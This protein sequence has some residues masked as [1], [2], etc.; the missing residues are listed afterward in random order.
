MYWQLH[1]LIIHLVSDD[2]AINLLWQRLLRGWNFSSS[3]EKPPAIRLKLAIVDEL[4]LLSDLTPFFSDTT[5]L[6]EDKRILSV[7]DGEGDSVRLYFHDGALIDVPLA[8]PSFPEVPTARG[9]LTRN[10]LNHG[11]FED[12]TF[13][14]LAPLLRRKG[15]FMVHAFGAAKD[16]QAALIVGPSGSGKTTTGLNLLL[17]DWDLLA[18]DVVLLKKQQNRILALPT[19]GGIGIRPQTVQLLPALRNLI[20]ARSIQ[21]QMDVTDAI[22]NITRW[23]EPAP[24][25]AVYFPQIEERSQ[26]S[27]QPKIKAVCLAE[28]MA[29]SMDQWDEALLPTHMNIL[30]ELS[31]QAEAY[32]LHLGQ[33]T[34]QIPSLLTPN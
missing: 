32:T 12:I 15:L 10:A 16:G 17:A 3:N 29:E 14:S 13:T 28:L 2:V 26:S 21:Q 18:N 8:T 30:Q 6:P 24:V 20:G 34:D 5:V 33:D 27:L 19:P 4:P 9:Y 22:M 31:H 25:T 1:N 7:Y 11:R 23:S